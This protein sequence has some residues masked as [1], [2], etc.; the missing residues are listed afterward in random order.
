MGRL[1]EI[2]EKTD[3]DDR[4][5]VDKRISEPPHSGIEVDGVSFQYEGP[6][7][8]YVLKDVSMHIPK[9]KVTAIVGT[10]GSGKTTLMKL[11][12]GFY[13]PVSG[14]ILIGEHNLHELPMKIWRTRCSTVM[15]DG[16]IFYDTIAR[17]IALDGEE[18]DQEKMDKAVVMANIR[19]VIEDLPLGYT[20]KIG[21]SGV[22]ISGG[23]RQRI[24]IARAVYKD[25]DYLFFDEATSSL[26]ANNEKIIIDNLNRFFVGRTVV[27]IAHRLSTVKNA[28]QIIVLEDG[29]VVEQGTHTH[30]TDIKGKY[31]E[32][33]KNQLEL[34]K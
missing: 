31:F 13:Q 2:H 29:M 11:L 21:S 10:S 28:D 8:N 12:L 1:Q 7:S 27:I 5:F 32:L 33:V 16:Y 30:L 25:P 34:G 26:D 19:D 20:T 6:N 22:G 23:Q 4:A 24:L 9:G 18:I 15:Q 14:R 3:E 17:N